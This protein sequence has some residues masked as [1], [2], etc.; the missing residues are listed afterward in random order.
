M[1][2]ATHYKLQSKENK[3]AEYSVKYSCQWMATESLSKV[4]LQRQK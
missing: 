3:L 2:G 1:S 4:A